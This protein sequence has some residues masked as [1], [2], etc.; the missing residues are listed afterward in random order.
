MSKQ[1][2]AWTPFPCPPSPTAGAQA[3]KHD[4]RASPGAEIRVEPLGTGT[5]HGMRANDDDDW[6]TTATTILLKAPKSADARP[7]RR[8][9]Q[10]SQG[11]DEAAK[12]SKHDEGHSRLF[13]N[14]GVLAASAF[15]CATLM[16]CFFLRS[17]T[18][19]TCGHIARGHQKA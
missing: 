8:V 7:I 19:A 3:V 10:D 15:L 2:D 5:V 17:R 11:G 9:I 18:W 16:L 14:V 4:W 1:V 6:D 12:T 13:I